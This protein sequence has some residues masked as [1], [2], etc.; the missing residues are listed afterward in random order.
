MY[1]KIHTQKCAS[2]E[3]HML[4]REM[5]LNGSPSETESNLTTGKFHLIAMGFDCHIYISR[6]YIV[7]CVYII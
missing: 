1:N 5:I 2:L 6:I 4:K 3:S 7:K